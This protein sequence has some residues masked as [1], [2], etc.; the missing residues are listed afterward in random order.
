MIYMKAKR[1]GTLSQ[2]IWFTATISLPVPGNS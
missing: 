2:S 1:Q